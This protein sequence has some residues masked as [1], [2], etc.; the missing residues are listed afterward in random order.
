M[1]IRRLDILN[2]SYT[3]ER[4][5]SHADS[6]SS[7]AKRQLCFPRPLLEQHPIRSSDTSC[8]PNPWRPQGSGPSTREC[9]SPGS[10][11]YLLKYRPCTRSRR[12]WISSTN[13]VRDPSC[14]ET[15]DRRHK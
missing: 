14:L 5:F 12:F 6:S 11:V 2:Q 4:S 3:L 1:T 7:T 13:E 15:P 8:E 9:E 10:A